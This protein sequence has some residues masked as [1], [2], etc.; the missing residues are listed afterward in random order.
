[1]RTVGESDAAFV[2][3]GYWQRKAAG[4]VVVGG[5]F[6]G[7]IDSPRLFARALSQDEVISLKRG[8]SSHAFGQA[9]IATWDFAA[10]ISSRKVT[11]T[12]PHAL[13]GQTVNMPARAMAGYNW[14]GKETN[15]HHALHEYG[16]IHFHDDDLDDAGWEVDFTLT[17]P[18]Q[19]K[20]GVY[21][22]RLRTGNA[23]DYIPFFVRPPKGTASA[24]IAF[25]APTNSYL[26][27][28]NEQI[29]DIS[30]LLA[31]NQKMEIVTP[32]DRYMVD[33]HLLSLYDRHSD[34]SG[35]CYSSRLRPILN[36][37]P[38]YYMKALQCPHQFG[39]DLH[40][41]DWLEAKGHTFDVITDEDLHVEGVDLL[42]HYKVILTG[43]HPEYWSGPM[44]AAMETYL[45][46]GGRLMYLGGNGFYG[47]VVR[48]RASAR[49][50]GASLGRHS[51]LGG[52][53][54]RVLSQHH[55]RARW[56][57]ALSR[58]SST[59]A[60]RCRFHCSGV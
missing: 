7:K 51:Y 33:H 28:A 13:H 38:K 47:Y 21:A 29:K 36:M 18:A 9:L 4:K 10:D 37:R 12:A 17:V 25:L 23:E 22:A 5:H 26:A 40:L 24:R 2:M 44:L 58:Q 41:V 42:A 1:V 20:S 3:A 46:N 57:L 49:D 11:D 34:G 32:E 35:V 8:A 27:Y 48:S 31:P 56:P 30:P 43:T 53:A 16:A 19:L 39:A 59:E 55:W 6:N 60:G 50:R 15:F 54:R 45:Q 52:H 14:A